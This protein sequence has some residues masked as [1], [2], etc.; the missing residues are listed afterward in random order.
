MID[1]APKPRIDSWAAS[2]TEAQRWDVYYHMRRGRWTEV[3]KWIEKEFEINPPSRSALYAFDKSMRQSEQAHRIEQ[4][5]IARQ[6]A[7]ELAASAGQNDLDLIEAYKAMGADL[8]LSLNDAAGATAFTKLALDLA[9][10]HNDK[11]TLEL[12]A[13][14]QKTKDKQLKLAR[15]KF[16]AAEKR[17][18]EVQNTVM[19]SAMTPEERES[20]LKAIFGL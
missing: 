8:A 20:K 14:A 5:V 9:S 17:L 11:V 13:A 10:S 18:N 16:E 3:A 19:D 1:I 15:E 12:K 7:G 2:L 6:E 4:A